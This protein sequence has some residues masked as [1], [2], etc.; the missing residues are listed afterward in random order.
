MKAS[1]NVFPLPSLT[2]EIKYIKIFKSEVNWSKVVAD[3]IFIL[4]I[5]MVMEWY[6]GNRQR[7]TM[8]RGF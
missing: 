6:K 2:T 4:N 7:G 8:F 5:T 1:N 3:T